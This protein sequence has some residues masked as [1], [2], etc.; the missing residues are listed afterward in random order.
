MN[1]IENKLWG[2][3]LIVLGT[4]FG[5]NALDITDINIFFDGWWTLFI[6][7]P[8]FINL[9]KEEDKKE[10]IIGIIIGICF[11]LAAQDI[12]TFEI[13]FKLLIPVILIIIGFSL[14][15]KDAIKQKI[16]TE[17][18]KYNKKDNKEYY[19]TFGGQNLVFNEN[20]EGCNLNAIFGGI[21]CDLKDIKLK[22]NVVINTNAIF[23]GVTIFVP[24]DIN[25]K[26]V[27]T[28]I[29]GGVTNKTNNKDAKKIIYINAICL[30]GGVEIKC[31]N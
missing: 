1:L 19:A 31:Q 6:I 13:I 9:F 3:L 17:M 5:L 29:F 25:V 11:L 18:K 10:N 23:G 14:I 20:F 16:K 27:S 8:C 28:A 4:I 7:V 21:K 15:F 24:N 2:I 12:I 22:E 30:F 26:V